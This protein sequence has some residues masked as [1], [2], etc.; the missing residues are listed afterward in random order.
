MGVHAEAYVLEAPRT[1]LRRTKLTLE[2]RDDEAIVEVLACGLCHTDLAFANGSV[3]P[4]HGFPLV[5]GHEVRGVHPVSR[6]ARVA[7][8]QRRG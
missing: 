6:Y 7:P 8:P 5:L 4:K 3:T 2:P 1:K